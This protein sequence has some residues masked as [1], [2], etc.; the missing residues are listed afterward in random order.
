MPV[1]NLAFTG[2]PVAVNGDRGQ[3]WN[4]AL[5]MTLSTAAAVR[6]GLNRSRVTWFSKG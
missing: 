5:V 1:S 4:S 3:V 6:S 2:E